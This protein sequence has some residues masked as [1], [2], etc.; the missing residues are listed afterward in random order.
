MIFCL[1]LQLGISLSLQNSP[2]E[3]VRNLF[4]L[5]MGGRIRHFYEFEDFRLDAAN[6]GLWRG[7]ELVAISPKALEVL[8]LLVARKGG[9]VSREE[10]IETVWKDTFVEE[11]NI[12]YTIS[13]LRKAF[14]NKDLIKTVARHGYRFTAIVKEISDD[15]VASS[16]LN[17]AQPVSVLKKSVFR[18]VVG[19]ALLTGLL[20]ATGF[21]YFWSSKNTTKSVNVPETENAEA[22]HIYLR[23]K[24]I[25]ENRSVENR[26]E[27][28]IDEFRQAIALDPTLAI[29]Y[30]GLAEGY[31]AAS[32]RL[33]NPKGLE[34]IAKA[35]TAAEKSLAL[36]PNLAEGYLV[37]GWLK[38][39]ADW[40]WPGAEADLRHAIELDPKSA[41]AHQ[42][43]AQTLVVVGKLDEALAEINKAYAIDPVSDLILGARFPI[44]EARGEFD[45]ALKESEEYLRENKNNNNAARAYAT[46]LYHKQ[47]FVQVIE[48]SEL[49]LA[50][51]SNKTAFAWLSL[52][53]SS[54]QKTSQ[55]EKA[56]VA[57]KQLEVLSQTDSKALYS[58]TMNYAEIGH[59]DEAIAALQKCF[60][61]HEE[62]MVWLNVEPRFANLRT[63]KRF[64][65]LIQKMK[66]A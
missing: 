27:K 49:N 61:M 14:D 51:S 1:T 55:P 58:L 29:A 46:F 31:A 32:V 13:L 38:R 47:D 24:M 2:L 15:G 23:G 5:Q 21:T 64:L 6:R 22:M 16:E 8:T 52:L 66:L 45:T 26:D 20:I 28:A 11:G 54:Y 30:A 60:E 4:G 50:K 39:N 33:P 62:R 65:E 7:N 48:A 17:P 19:S 12:N 36:N 9:I 3:V 34:T 42:R 59:K 35:K 56:D 57:L 53:A 37:R 41:T 40:D 25:L 10:L 44:F 43:L 63:D 18:W